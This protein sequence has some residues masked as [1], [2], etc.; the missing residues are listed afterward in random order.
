MKV[1]IDWDDSSEDVSKAIRDGITNM[2]GVNADPLDVNRF[3]AGT[4]E[5]ST[6]PSSLRDIAEAFESA[7][8]RLEKLEN[9]ETLHDIE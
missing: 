2:M 1:V 6:D 4:D 7:A 3:N 9:Q 8:N 5:Y